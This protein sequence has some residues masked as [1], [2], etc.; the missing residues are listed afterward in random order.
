MAR[1]EL[2]ERLHM[3]RLSRMPI[4]C[5]VDARV[6]HRDGIPT[7]RAA[8]PAVQVRWPGSM[9]CIRYRSSSGAVDSDDGTS[10]Q[11][12]GSSPASLG[13]LYFATTAPVQLLYRLSHLCFPMFRRPCPRGFANS[14]AGG[15]SETTVKAR[16]GERHE[17][18]DA[19]EGKH[20]YRYPHCHLMF[21]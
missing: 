13:L 20:M 15:V 1:N 10:P 16:I 21:K 3:N 4:N 2:Q 14:C 12:C 7:A 17:S 8:A 11:N 9:V 5:V 6:S 19:Q 18:R